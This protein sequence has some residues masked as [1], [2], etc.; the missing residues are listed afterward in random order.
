MTQFRRSSTVVLAGLV[1][2][3]FGFALTAIPYAAAI[4]PTG[5]V[6][7]FDV[8]GT[9]AGS[10]CTST[11]WNGGT[12][13]DGNIG[14]AGNLGVASNIPIVANGEEI[15]LQLVLTDQTPST[16]F[17]VSDPG[18]FLTLLVGS[19]TLL[20]NAAGN[21]TAFMIFS[22]SGLS[23]DCVTHPIMISPD[24]S[25][26]ASTKNQIHHYYG[27][28][29]S[30]GGVMPFPPPPLGVPQFPLGS[31]ATALIMAAGLAGLLLVKKKQLKV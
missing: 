2:T 22:V 4:S 21:A 20:T 16:S 12:F 18:G 29:G 30:C 13:S 6:N 9:G 10:T 23:G 31:I 3:L 27:G 14:F 24:V 17:T 8:S 11:V 7:F 26:T 15:C 5:Q 25:D 28:A 19:T 1:L